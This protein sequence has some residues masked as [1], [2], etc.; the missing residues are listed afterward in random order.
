MGRYYNGD[1]EGKF[2][3][4]VQSSSDANFFGVEGVEPECTE[5]EYCFEDD[6]VSDVKKGIKECKKA[7]GTFNGKLDK[8]FKEVKSYN[9]EELSKVLGVSVK[10]TG[11]YLEWYARLKLGQKILNCLKEKGS[12]YFS[13][14]Y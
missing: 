5:L 4:G 13:A 10:E 1:I 2:W 12:C 6:S 8:F 3:F 14:E 11:Q 9:D 7:L